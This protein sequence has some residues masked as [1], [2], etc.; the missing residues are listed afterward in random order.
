[1]SD[2]LAKMLTSAEGVNPPIFSFDDVSPWPAGE[3]ERCVAAGLL[4]PGRSA[5]VLSC[6]ECGESE[7]VFHLQNTPTKQSRAYSGA[8]PDAGLSQSTIESNPTSIRNIDRHDPVSGS[9]REKSGVITGELKSKVDRIWD[10]MW[11]GGISN[12]L[13]VIEQL[14]YL[15]FIKRLDELHTLRERKSARTGKPIEEPIFNKKQG[16]LRWSRF[17]PTPSCWRLTAWGARTRR[18]PCRR[19]RNSWRGSGNTA[20]YSAPLLRAPLVDSPR[21]LVKPCGDTGSPGCSDCVTAGPGVGGRSAVVVL[22]TR[23]RGI[24]A[25]VRRPPTCANP[26]GA[27][28]STSLGCPNTDRKTVRRCVG[29]R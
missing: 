2:V 9:K 6:P 5:T 20:T 16:H 7:E 15:L 28:P 26:G 23:K 1:M 11:S 29:P 4:R 22:A 17:G 3:L 24:A 18:V 19:R 12:P 14:T 10:T 25:V 27:T 8:T 21:R 13:S